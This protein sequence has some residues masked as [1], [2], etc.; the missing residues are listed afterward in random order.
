MLGLSYHPTLTN[1]ET[2]RQGKPVDCKLDMLSA[3]LQQRDNVEV[4]SWSTLQAALKRMRE[5][6]IA[7]RITRQLR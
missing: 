6:E 2:Y 7:D 4:P 5:N 1:I 3:W